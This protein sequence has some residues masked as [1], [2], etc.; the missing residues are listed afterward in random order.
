V[1]VPTAVFLV[2]V[3]A[4]HAPLAR[5]PRSHGVAVVLAAVVTLGVAALTTVGLPLAWVVLLICV[6]VAALVAVGV[7]DQHRRAATTRQERR[8]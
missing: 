2:L 6:P 4:I 1:A 8:R 5:P 3:W 7:T